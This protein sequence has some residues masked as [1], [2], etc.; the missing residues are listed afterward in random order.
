M[1]INP[2]I[3]KWERIKDKTETADINAKSMARAMVGI[4]NN[5]NNHQTEV[6]KSVVEAR[7]GLKALMAAWAMSSKIISFM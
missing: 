1:W 6:D 5:L 2:K 7:K 4:N 3:K